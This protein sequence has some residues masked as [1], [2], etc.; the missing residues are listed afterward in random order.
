M[1]DYTTQPK[2][3]ATFL[4][5]SEL[6]MRPRPRWLVDNM[7][8]EGGISLF[9]GAPAS[10]K[11]F[12]ALDIALS[13]ATGTHAFGNK[14]FSG[15]VVYVAA[16]GV[17]SIIERTESWM[18]GQTDFYPD[19]F[20][21]YDEPVDLGNK[22][23]AEWFA[24]SIGI[25]SL[26]VIDT[27]ARCAPGLD[28]NDASEMGL[29]IES[30]AIIAK[31]TKA[32]VIIIH[33]NNKTGTARGSTALPAAVDT[34]IAVTRNSNTVTLQMLKQKDA[35]EI[36]PI[37]L[38]AVET[39]DSLKLTL[40]PTTTKNQQAIINALKDGPKSHSELIKS[41]ALNPTPFQRAMVANLNAN[42]VA[43]ELKNGSERKKIYHLLF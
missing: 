2:P 25:A 29:F 37:T 28:E 39:K 38:Q 31:Q 17:H 12:V 32:H 11:S 42:L 20:A 41:T 13:V 1:A 19:N 22:Q 9:T 30:V 35:E 16:E 3:K 36:E 7:L 33:H 21:I 34:H 15:K 18:Q 27:L 43:F 5:L 14:T 26:I 23:T 40:K 24:D 6:A 10:F 8:V 4:T